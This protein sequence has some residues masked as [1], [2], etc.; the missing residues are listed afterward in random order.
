[1]ETYTERFNEVYAG[2]LKFF[3]SR[4]FFLSSIPASLNTLQPIL[5]LEDSEVAVNSDFTNK[6]YNYNYH[7]NQGQLYH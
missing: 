1:M 5:K 4:L 6:I 2:F 7:N 3:V